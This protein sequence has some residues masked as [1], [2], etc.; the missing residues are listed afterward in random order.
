MCLAH[1][2]YNQSVP[3][4]RMQIFKRERENSTG[5]APKKMRKKL[6]GHSHLTAEKTPEGHEAVPTSADEMRRLS[7]LR[8]ALKVGRAS[9][10]MQSGPWAVPGYPGTCAT[11]L[12][13]PLSLSFTKQKMSYD[14]D[15]AYGRRDASSG[16]ALPHSLPS[17]SLGSPRLHIL[18]HRLIKGS[19]NS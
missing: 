10:S 15:L 3:G 5:S 13:P 8:L 4:T 16:S 11:F 19:N 9:F 7:R 12:S 17:L 18:G 1:N 2:A 6:N 14:L